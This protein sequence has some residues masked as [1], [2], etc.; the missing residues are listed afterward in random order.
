MAFNF[1]ARS[2]GTEGGG[3]AAEEL[4]RIPQGLLCDVIRILSDV[5]LI[6]EIEG[7]GRAMGDVTNVRAGR[8]DG[9]ASPKAY[10]TG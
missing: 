8:N 4:W 3:R 9:P 2:G 5:A 7:E 6:I 1:L 10:R